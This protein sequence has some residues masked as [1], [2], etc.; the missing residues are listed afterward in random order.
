MWHNH[1]HPSIGHSKKLKA[2]KI[3]Q[4]YFLKKLKFLTKIKFQNALSPFRAL[5][6]LSYYLAFL[7][8]LVR[9]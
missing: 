3:S 4:H 6:L 8:S 7:F 2:L 9:I 5:H 1:I